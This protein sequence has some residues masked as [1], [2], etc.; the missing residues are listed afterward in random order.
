MWEKLPL[1]AALKIRFVKRESSFYRRQ[2]KSKA[3]SRGSVTEIWRRIRKNEHRKSDRLI[4]VFRFRNDSRKG[5][6]EVPLTDFCSPA[7]KQPLQVGVI[8]ELP[9][10]LAIKER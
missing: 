9:K 7:H 5:F 6:F 10:S 2:A 8:F 1:R 4:N 3:H